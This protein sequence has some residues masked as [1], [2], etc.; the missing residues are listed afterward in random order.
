MSK[1]VIDYLHKKEDDLIKESNRFRSLQNRVQELES[2]SGG[3]ATPGPATEVVSENVAL[4]VPTAGELNVDFTEASVQ[5]NFITIVDDASRTNND[6]EG[7]QVLVDAVGNIYSF[8]ISY[9]FSNTSFYLVKQTAEGDLI[10]QKRYYST[11]GSDAELP[12]NSAAFDSDGN[13]IINARYSD[14]FVKINADTGAVIWSVSLTWSLGSYSNFSRLVLDSSNNFYVAYAKN[15]Q[16]NDTDYSFTIV[17]LSGATGAILI[18]RSFTLTGLTSIVDR[19]NNFRVGDIKV[20]ASG[21]LYIAHSGSGT[22]SGS[23]DQVGKGYVWKV[24]ADL[25]TIRWVKRL[26]TN[27]DMLS[28]SPRIAEN[29]TNQQVYVT[30]NN[31]FFRFDADG[32]LLSSKAVKNS[33]DFYP[34]HVDVSYILGGQ[35]EYG[36]RQQNTSDYDWSMFI[37]NNGNLITLGAFGQKDGTIYY[38]SAGFFRLSPDLSALVDQ[39]TLEVADKKYRLY[40]GNNY[41]SNTF[42]DY[43]KSKSKLLLSLTR[44][45]VN[46]R[47]ALPEY[48]HVTAVVDPENITTGF[49]GQFLL[50]KRSLSDFSAASLA[51]PTTTV[52]T[53]SAGNTSSAA[54]TTV[55]SGT[56]PVTSV[57]SSLVLENANID[58]IVLSG[59]TLVSAQAVSTPHLAADIVQT[60]RL[61][62]PAKTPVQG[63]TEANVTGEIYADADYLYIAVGT[64]W[65]RVALSTF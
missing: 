52:A 2:N 16:T 59:K 54:V 17:K 62:V 61:I 34:N 58:R 50:Q 14:V 42:Y 25:Q 9:D 15:S 31:E 41:M 21:D 36:P 64:G 1:R 28:T 8:M 45:G 47:G 37:D 40:G 26:T 23:G 30:L 65:K 46:F 19:T 20:S 32:T 11:D 38:T 5:S 48:R 3:P 43:V 4:T 60:K 49:Y 44:Q 22:K 55:T 6:I 13:I 53:I 18:Q 57:A 35:A 24:S 12:A 27:R 39:I 7:T 51:T 29:S 63:A 56:I 33:G 10:W